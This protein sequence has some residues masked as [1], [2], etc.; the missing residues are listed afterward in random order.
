M[1]ALIDGNSFYCSCER[2]FE[3]KLRNVP[4]VVLSN[5]DGC[6]IARTNEAKDLGIKMGDPWHL[7]AKRPE[8]KPVQWRSSNYSLYGDMSRRMYQLLTAEVPRVEPYSIDEMFLD[9]G[10]LAGDLV[11]LSSHL[12]DMVRRVAK[13]PTCVGI[14]P[15]KTIAKLANK[16]AKKDRNGSGICDLRSKSDRT[17]WYSKLALDEVWGVGRA[18]VVKLQK[19]GAATV[20]DFVAMEPDY[21]RDLMTVTGLRTHAE[22]RGTVCVGMTGEAATRKSIAV[23]RSFGHL[24]TTWEEMREAVASYATRAAEKL[25]S[26]G[27]QAAAMQ[28]FM[29]TNTFSKTDRQYSAGKTIAIEATADT[30]AMIPA[31]VRLARSLWRPGF[32]YQKAGVILVDLYK[33]TE[34]PMEMFP[35]RDPEKAARLMKAMDAI[36]AHEGKG[37]IRPA[38]VPGTAAWGGRQRN[39]SP[40]YTTRLE[41]ILRA[42]T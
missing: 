26:H 25:R 39:V 7:V 17:T 27:L 2:A 38:Q 3:P 4:L 33:A 42:Q 40:R 21:V 34:L 20:A 41:E 23:T 36:N 37:T 6:V 5:N 29:N 15:T 13:I 16:I 24:V 28:V 32:R 19:A 18:S 12:R 10:G 31:A 9:Y 8:L 14:G 1:F 22:L 30:L 35:S 11:S